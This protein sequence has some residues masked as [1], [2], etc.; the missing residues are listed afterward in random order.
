ME[1]ETEASTG[2]SDHQ[3]SAGD[4]DDNDG[5]VSMFSLVVDPAPTRAA[6][7]LAWAA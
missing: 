7:P 6:A 2:E 4:E 5:E 3:R 1:V